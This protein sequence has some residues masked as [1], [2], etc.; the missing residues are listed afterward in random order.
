[1][2]EKYIY[3][4]EGIYD[5]KT[6]RPIRSVEYIFNGEKM[7]RKLFILG[8]KKW[9]NNKIDVI[10]SFVVSIKD[11]LNSTPDEIITNLKKKIDLAWSINLNEEKKWFN[12]PIIKKQR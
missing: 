10:D 11:I 5:I 4:E 1:M 8:D 7:T 3:I 2:S 6:K 9:K 12:Y